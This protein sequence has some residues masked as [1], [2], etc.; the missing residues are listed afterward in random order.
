[1]GQKENERQQISTYTN[2]KVEIMEDFIE[3]YGSDALNPNR[4][5]SSTSALTLYSVLC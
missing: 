3:P 5:I 2:C 4:H 1:M